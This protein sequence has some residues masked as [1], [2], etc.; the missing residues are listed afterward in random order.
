MEKISFNDGIQL[1]LKLT[2][3]WHKDILNSVTENRDQ[4]ISNDIRELRSVIYK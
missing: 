3:V 4:N 2:S 1:L